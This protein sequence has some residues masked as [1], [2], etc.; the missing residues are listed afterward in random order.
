MRKSIFLLFLLAAVPVLVTAQPTVVRPLEFKTAVIPFQNQTGDSSLDYLSLGV[1]RLLASRLETTG[2]VRETRARNTFI[3]QPDKGLPESNGTEGLRVLPVNI[4]LREEAEWAKLAAVKEARFLCAKLKADAWIS[5][6]VAR[7]AEGARDLII[8]IRIFRCDT[9]QETEKTFTRALNTI[10]RNLDE[11]AD[12]IQAA[13]IGEKRYSV[14][15]ES[16]EAGAMIF[17]D[18]IYVG[19]SP[20]VKPVIPGTYLVR[21]DAEGHRPFEQRIDVKSDMKLSVD[22]PATT[23]RGALRVTSDPEGASVYL[24]MTFLGKTPLERKDLPAGTHRL[25]ISAE[26][27]VDRFIGVV[28][29]DET[30]VD[31]SVHLAEGDTVKVYKDPG[32]VILD[33]TRHDFSLYSALSS[34]LF[35]AGWAHY[36]V[37]ADRIKDSL[38]TYVPSLLIT[39]VPD[40]TLYEMYLYRQN[41]KDAK[42]ELKKA[43]VSGGIGIGLIFLS[44]FFLYSGIAHDDKEAGEVS[45]RPRFQFGMIPGRREQTYAAG[46]SL[47]F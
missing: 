32:Y 10:Y 8:R 33:W 43:E 28:L 12:V 6:S 21:A 16:T 42:R 14:S 19:R 38:S 7:S 36:R 44:G 13:L 27:R 9:G 18:G 46:F 22:S 37:R 20:I 41:E 25:R 15:F 4:V 34:G 30:P 1:A 47:R 24:D 2:F 31:V 23:N 26:G 35:Y 11:P 5:G 45:M 29:K 17:L 40:R 3:V 39:S